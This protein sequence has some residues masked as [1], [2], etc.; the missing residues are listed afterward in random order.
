MKNSAPCTNFL[1]TPADLW[2]RR[3]QRRKSRICCHESVLKHANFQKTIHTTNCFQPESNLAVG[4]AC[5]F[6]AGCCDCRRHET[7]QEF[8][9]ASRELPR[10]GDFRSGCSQ[11]RR[12]NSQAVWATTGHH[13]LERCAWK[14]RDCCLFIVPY[15][16]PAKPSEQ[17]GPRSGRVSRWDGVLPRHGQLPVMPQ[18]Q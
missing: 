1:M 10:H 14:Q 8:R 16:S 3:L 15:D 18:L 9:R 2:K 5:R 11:I 12:R 7:R 13:R 4:T 6:A 17:D